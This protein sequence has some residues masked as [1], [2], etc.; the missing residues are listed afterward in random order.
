MSVTQEAKKMPV[1]GE[2]FYLEIP[3]PYHPN[4][5]YV[6]NLF[7]VQKVDKIYFTCKAAATNDRY[8]I[9]IHHLKNNVFSIINFTF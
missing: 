3:I 8:K 4:S 6:V 5:D 9:P 7:V 1:V 2:Y